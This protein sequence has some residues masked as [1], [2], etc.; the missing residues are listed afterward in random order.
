MTSFNSI[1]T[2]DQIKIVIGAGYFSFYQHV[3]N[4][5]IGDANG[6]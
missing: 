3:A 2:I 5:N 1:Q 6:S 4:G